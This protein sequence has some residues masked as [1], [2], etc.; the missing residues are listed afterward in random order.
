MTRFTSD[1]ARLMRI[2]VDTNVMV[3]ARD[4]SWDSLIV[5]AAQLA[6]CRYLLTED[7]Q[8]GLEADGLTVTDPFVHTPDA[9]I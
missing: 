5:A 4:A 6:D 7:L 8:D 1:K 2:F 9:L 3:Y